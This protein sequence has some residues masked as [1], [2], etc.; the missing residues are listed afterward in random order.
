MTMPSSTTVRTVA[1]NVVNQVA[2][3][4][5]VVTASASAAAVSLQ[6]AGLWFW[7]ALQDSYVSKPEE[8]PLQAP[9][10]IELQPEPDS[11]ECPKSEAPKS[12]ALEHWE[13]I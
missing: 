5:P 11:S 7:Q 2:D 12:E 10:G 3:A 6:N 8:P 1:A 13:H 9:S 4:L